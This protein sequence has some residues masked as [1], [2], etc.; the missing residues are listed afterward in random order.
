MTARGFFAGPGAMRALL[1]GPGAVRALRPGRRGVVELVLSGGVYVRLGD[2]WLLLADPGAPFGPLSVAVVGL[3]R[4][5][6]R[7]GQAVVV[8]PTRLLAG[9]QAVC[10][11]RLRERLPAPSPRRWRA[12]VAT[13][14]VARG[15]AP[16]ATKAAAPSIPPG[17]EPAVAKAAA[18]ALALVPAPPEALE[19]GLGA[20]RRGRT[21]DAV[22]RLAGHGEGLT[23]AGDDALAGYAAWRHASGAPTR[24]SAS[25]AG[26]SS[27]L[28]HAYLR[29]AERG[30]L[31]DAGAAVLAAVCAGDPRAA[32]T[33]AVALRD[34]GASS[35]AA[36]LWGMA[37]G[38]GEWLAVS[39]DDDP[40]VL[41][42]LER[43]SLG[44]PVQPALWMAD[45]ADRGLADVRRV[46]VR[47]R[48]VMVDDALRQ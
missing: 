34:W 23:P 7:P 36:L 25:A 21:R 10:L 11:E 31:P 14:A 8:E 45:H 13:E 46:Q 3:R 9:G 20:L 48:A 24:L 44:A 39:H 15:R 32:A 17:A 27:P 35:G 5:A 37:A 2:D 19:P 33:A 12:P 38:L 4:S 29:C 26:R 18:A 42:V 47:R 1:A 30:E 41:E 43:L 22:R 16:I 6:L 40:Q 28:G